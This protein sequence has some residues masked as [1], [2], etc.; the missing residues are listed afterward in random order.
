MGR[1]LRPRPALPVPALESSTSQ[2]QCEQNKFDAYANRA[3]ILCRRRAA[4]LLSAPKLRSGCMERAARMPVDRR[5]KTTQ[6]GSSL[7]IQYILVLE[8]VVW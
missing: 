6:K 5:M 1:P 8:G 2:T 3:R 7:N 4:A